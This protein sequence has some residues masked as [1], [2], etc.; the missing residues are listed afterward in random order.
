MP[1]VF[2]GSIKKSSQP[3]ALRNHLLSL[4][5]VKKVKVLYPKK[6]VIKKGFSILDLEL[7]NISLSEFLLLKIPF[8]GAQLHLTEYLEGNQIE[9][10]N[11]ELSQKKVYV[12]NV[13]LDMDNATLYE[14]FKPFGEIETAYVSKANAS[15]AFM[16]AFVTF[17]TSEAAKACI[18]HKKVM[19]GERCL[20]VK[21][22]TPKVVAKASDKSEGY[23]LK[24]KKPVVPLKRK[25]A[26]KLG[27]SETQT[28]RKFT[29]ESEYVKKNRVQEEHA[30]KGSK[31]DEANVASGRKRT[32]QRPK[33]EVV[34][35]RVPP[36]NELITACA[37]SGGHEQGNLRFNFSKRCNS[38]QHQSLP[39]IYFEQGGSFNRT[40][41]GGAGPHMLTG[42]YNYL[43]A[44]G[45]QNWPFLARNSLLLSKDPHHHSPHA[46]KV[47]TIG[48][49]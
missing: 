29:G 7:K 33:E 15:K 32:R 20:R 24:R 35:E 31:Q 45:V 38:G 10:R 30:D 11:Q 12:C 40:S 27:S 41:V 21:P 46:L 19:F 39:G 34:T 17:I 8:A 13:P 23:M 26:R 3:S 22:F 2:I 5:S 36:V 37:I 25:K 48:R 9:K 6:G 44:P 47:H 1:K 42:G 16:Y 28:K 18:D 14:L 43:I 49:F 4:P